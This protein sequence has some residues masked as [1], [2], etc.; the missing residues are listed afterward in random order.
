MKYSFI[1]ETF[2]NNIPSQNIQNIQNQNSQSNNI[3][4]EQII[5]NL[6]E[7]NFLIINKQNEIDMIKKLNKVQKLISNINVKISEITSLNSQIVTENNDIENLEKLKNE[8]KILSDQQ[9]AKVDIA[10]GKYVQY[11]GEG[12]PSVLNIKGPKGIQ[13][14]CKDGKKGEI[15]VDDEGTLNILNNKKKGIKIDRKG[16]LILSNQLSV[17]G[18]TIKFTSDGSLKI[19]NKKGKGIEL[20]SEG[21]INIDNDF[22]IN[23]TCI[24]RSDIKKLNDKVLDGIMQKVTKCTDYQNF[25]VKNYEEDENALEY[26]TNAIFNSEVK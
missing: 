22:C 24:K 18:N 3:T 6:N 25:K 16:G 20:N 1:N 5:K 15:F 11:T 10:Y 21:D 13:Y 14:K 17:S 23:G 4:K 26:V 9:L 8:N 2:E 7:N 12:R 19:T